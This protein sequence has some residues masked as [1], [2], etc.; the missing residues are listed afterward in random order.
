VEHFD[1]ANYWGLDPT[2]FRTGAG[3]YARAGPR[4]ADFFGTGGTDPQFGAGG[5]K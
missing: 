3:S 2:P 4:G 5:K 1:S